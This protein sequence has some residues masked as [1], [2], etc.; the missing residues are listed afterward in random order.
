[1]PRQIALWNG[2]DKDDLLRLPDFL[3]GLMSGSSGQKMTSRH[4][5]VV[6][7]TRHRISSAE[8][9]EMAQSSRMRLSALLE[10]F[11]ETR[12]IGHKHPPLL[13]NRTASPLL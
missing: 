9:L 4:I 1:M 2:G 5:G 6:R 11:A 10:S 3:I 12:Q 7:R 13:T 8:K